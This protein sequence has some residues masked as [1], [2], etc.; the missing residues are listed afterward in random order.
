V[1]VHVSSDEKG[2]LPIESVDRL[3][4]EETA[5]I[6]ITNP[7]TLGLFEENIKKIADIVHTRG[8][9]VYGDGANMNA[10][11]GIIDPKEMGIDVLHL[12]L[13]KTFSTPQENWLRAV[14]VKKTRTL[15]ARPQNR[16]KRW[17]VLP[18]RGFPPFG[19]KTARFLRKFWCHG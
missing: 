7:N 13:H 6:M 18:L 3:M 9:L 17:H 12:N 19:R 10:V 8:G 11:M 4:D 16:G 2:I 1:P 5:G 14:C 15:L